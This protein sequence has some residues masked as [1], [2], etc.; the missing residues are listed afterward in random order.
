[1]LCRG[2]GNNHTLA[3]S[4]SLLGC[5][6]GAKQRGDDKGKSTPSRMKTTQSGRQAGQLGTE[7]GQSGR[8]T[9]QS[10]READ[11]MGDRRTVWKRGRTVW[12][13]EGLS[14]RKKDSLGERPVRQ[15]DRIIKGTAKRA[16]DVGNADTEK[17]GHIS[18][19]SHL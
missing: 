10:G 19:C 16:R 6:S 18:C 1:M 14:G 7:A 2:R 17:H 12:E 4:K 11:S 9:G 8:E 5:Q 3:S 15:R 13:K